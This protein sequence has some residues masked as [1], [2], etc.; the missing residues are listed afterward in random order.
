M[1]FDVFAEDPFRRSLLDDSRDFGPKVPGISFAGSSPGTAEGLAGISGRDDM[2]AATPCAAVE[3][4]KVIPDR[5][6]IQGRVIHPGHESGRSMGFP[7][8]ETNSSISGFCDMQAEVQAAV[9]GAQ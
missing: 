1:P 5:R 9:S 2:N 6:M 7:L 8:D 4:F 3:G